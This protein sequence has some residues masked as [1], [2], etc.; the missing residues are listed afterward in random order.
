MGHYFSTI[1]CQNGLLL[2]A[3]G[4]IKKKSIL[5]LN[6]KSSKSKY[7]KKKFNSIIPLS[8]PPLGLLS[9]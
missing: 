1:N 3:H 8:D 7:L 5:Y 6:F 2:V 9:F 4:D